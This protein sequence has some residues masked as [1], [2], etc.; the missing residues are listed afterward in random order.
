M[1]RIIINNFTE[2]DDISVLK[3][4]QEVIKLDRISNNGK[5]YCY[6]VS[7]DINGEEFMMCTKLRKTSDVFNF[8]KI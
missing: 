3:L 8:Y 1:S 2:I 6:A 4:V 5:Q 7:F